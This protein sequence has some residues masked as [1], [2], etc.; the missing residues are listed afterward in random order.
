MDL[1]WVKALISFIFT[2]CISL[3]VIALFEDKN[4]K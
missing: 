3:N 1:K 4:Y 2:I